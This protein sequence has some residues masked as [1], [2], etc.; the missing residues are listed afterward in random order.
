MATTPRDRLAARAAGRSSIHIPSPTELANKVAKVPAPWTVAKRV[1]NKLGYDKSGGPI[2]KLEK[3]FRDPGV[4][5]PASKPDLYP[6]VPTSQLPK[7]R[8]KRR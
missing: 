8:K 2:G 3:H 6:K 5:V 4:A 7:V 1:A